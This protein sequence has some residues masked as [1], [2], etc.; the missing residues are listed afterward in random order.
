[1]VNSV[2]FEEENRWNSKDDW[3]IDEEEIDDDDDATKTS[4][5][6]DFGSCTVSDDDGSCLL[7]PKYILRVSI[8]TPVSYLW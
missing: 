5:M 1:M 3:L 7:E 6:I 2:V 4:I 8:C